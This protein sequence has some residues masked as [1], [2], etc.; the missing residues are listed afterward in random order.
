MK[1]LKK[2][3]VDREG[4]RKRLKSLKNLPTMPGV[5]QEINKSIQNPETTAED[6]AKIISS[7]QALSA[8]ILR[9][10]N[11]VLYGFPRRISNIR[12]ALII[13]GFDVVKGLLLSSSVFDIMLARGFLGLW[14]HSIGCAISAGV[15][16]KKL[17]MPDPEEV[18]VAA[19]LHDLGK[20]IIKLELPEE[21]SLIEQKVI[22]N[23]I[24]I[25]EAEKDILG[26]THA[27]V[28]K[29]L[30]QEWYLPNKLAYPITYHH[31][32]NLSEFAMQSTAVVH[33]ADS[34]VRGIGFGF[35]GDNFVP[36]IDNRAWDILGISDPFLEEIIREIDEKLDNAETMYPENGPDI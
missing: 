26:F 12:H 9:I 34:L 2:V 35:A 20:V 33:V 19:L 25:Y 13:L 23:H 15:I 4:I 24:S 17:N 30:C 31:Q 22:D 6:I 8:K 1:R 11:S 7:D 32:P 21:S 16:A 5:F 3:T 28:G 14:Q 29:W 27:T 10:V 18:F 36:K